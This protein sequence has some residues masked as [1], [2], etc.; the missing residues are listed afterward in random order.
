[1][2]DTPE[3]L[4][5]RPRVLLFTHQCHGGDLVDQIAK[6]SDVYFCRDNENTAPAGM[7]VF[8]LP[9]AWKLRQAVAKNQYDLIISCANFEPLWRRNKN[10]FSNAWRCLKKIVFRPNSLGFYFL[11]WIIGKSKTPLAV[12]DWED[13]TIID[14]THWRLLKRATCYFKTQLPR[15]PYKAFLF[16]DK[17]NDCLFNIVRQP[18]YSDWARKLRPIPMGVTVPKNWAELRNAEKKTDIFFAGPTHYS[19]ARL[20]GQRQLQ[21]LRDEGYKIDLHVVSATVPGIPRD[22]FLRRCAE[23]WLVWSPEGAG[24]DCMRHYWAPLMGSV[25]LLNH[26]DTFRHRPLI[27]QVHAFYYGVEGDDLKRVARMALSD[28]A[29]LRQMAA[30]GEEFVRTTHTHPILAEHMISETLRTAAVG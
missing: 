24:W 10:W 8:T 26:P 13:N 22:E 25:P 20:E 6:R 23:A 21:E 9:D 30:Q 4:S 1:M 28:K 27:D 19:W 5:P 17:R 29:R 12:Y 11:P 18:I 15:N 3:A 2:P 14:R 7:K 16:Q